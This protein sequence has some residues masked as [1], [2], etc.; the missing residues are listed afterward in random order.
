MAG[1]KSGSELARIQR[2]AAASRSLPRS[3]NA[4]RTI[5]IPILEFSNLRRWQMSSPTPGWKSAGQPT[6]QAGSRAG[7][8]IMVT[9]KTLEPGSRSLRAASLSA[10]TCCRSLDLTSV[11]NGVIFLRLRIVGPN[12]AYAEKIIQLI[13]RLPIP[14]TEIPPTDHPLQRQQQPASRR[15]RPASRQRNFHRDTHPDAH[16]ADGNPSAPH[17]RI[18]KPNPVMVL[19]NDSRSLEDHLLANL[20][21]NTPVLPSRTVVHRIVSLMLRHERQ[22]VVPGAMRWKC[23]VWI[24]PWSSHAP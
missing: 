2:Y 8:W 20:R 13:V 5:R 4:P 9:V 3:A 16:P 1:D 15:Q 23:D 10:M 18:P 6:R 17:Q 19:F 12:D 24:C 7:R 11:Q 21:H 22:L 14:P